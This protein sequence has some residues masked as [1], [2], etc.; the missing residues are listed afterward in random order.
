MKLIKF[1]ILAFAALA[2][3]LCA[4][5]AKKQA[6]APAPGYVEYGK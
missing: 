2:S 1:S 5:C 6:A 3:V 4:S